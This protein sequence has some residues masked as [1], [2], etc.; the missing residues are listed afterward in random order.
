MPIPIIAV[1][2]TVVRS[3]ALTLG[4]G[5]Q[6]VLTMMTFCFR[7]NGALA[8]GLVAREEILA[9]TMR[10]PKPC[11]IRM[12]HRFSISKHVALQACINCSA[13]YCRMHGR[14][15]F[16]IIGDDTR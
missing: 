15:L 11:M 14:I 7:S 12:S 13:I 5:A 9:G 4:R 10:S 3:L 16:M 6:H 1:A 2:L 8:S